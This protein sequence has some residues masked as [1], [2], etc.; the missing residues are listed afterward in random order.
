MRETE[1]SLEAILLLERVG[2]LAEDSAPRPARL[3]G[4]R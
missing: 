3:P 4:L 2:D 1:R